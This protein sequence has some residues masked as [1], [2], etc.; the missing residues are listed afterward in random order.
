MIRCKSE[1][2]LINH[3]STVWPCCWILTNKHLS[4]ALKNAPDGWNNLLQHDLE[5]I[6]KH[7]L[8]RK[9]FNNKHWN[10]DTKCDEI[11]KRMCTVKK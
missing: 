9:H 2:L 6:L 8:F 3:D 4:T 10:D 5:T 1:G 7:N 11:C